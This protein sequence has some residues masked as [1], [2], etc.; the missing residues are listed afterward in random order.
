M[1]P[2]ASYA[3]QSTCAPVPDARA[4]S[5]PASAPSAAVWPIEHNATMRGARTGTSSER[6]CGK[7]VHEATCATRSDHRY[8]A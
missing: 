4:R 1:L 8:E 3:A 5:T 7:V 2:S 6:P